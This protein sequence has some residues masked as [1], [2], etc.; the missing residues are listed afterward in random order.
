MFVSSSRSTSIYYRIVDKLVGM[1]G[2][3][4]YVDLPAPVKTTESTRP[5][6]EGYRINLATNYDYFKIIIFLKISSD[7]STKN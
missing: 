4:L 3:D 5:K 1:I 6:A 2:Y 7:T